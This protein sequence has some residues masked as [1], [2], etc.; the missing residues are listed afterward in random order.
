MS[1]DTK[2]KTIS[3]QIE[4]GKTLEAIEALKKARQTKISRTN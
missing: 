1:Q 3:K 2:L 4:T